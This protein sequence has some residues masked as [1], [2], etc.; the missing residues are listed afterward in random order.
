MAEI[1]DFGFTAVN[2]DE[3]EVTQTM[4]TMANEAKGAQQ[5]L[6]ELYTES[7]VTHKLVIKEESKYVKINC[8]TPKCKF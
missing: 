4:H 5:K 3:L 1:F 8:A 7:G 2:E 6:D